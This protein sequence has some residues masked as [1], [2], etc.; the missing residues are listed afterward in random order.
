MEPQYEKIPP[1]AHSN[2]E[3]TIKTRKTKQRQ[4]DKLR[5]KGIK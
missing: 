2:T 5:G 3:E 1:K 4:P